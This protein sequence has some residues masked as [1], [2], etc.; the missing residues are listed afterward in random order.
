MLQQGALA[1][2]STDIKLIFVPLIFV[3]LR[4]WS[5]IIDIPTFY[6]PSA[7]QLYGRATHTLVIVAVGL[8]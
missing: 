7:K 3:L 8:L 4:M 1:R 6:D 5:A 2:R